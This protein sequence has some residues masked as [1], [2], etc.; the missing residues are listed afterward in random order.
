MPAADPPRQRLTP[1]ERAVCY[2][3][4]PRVIHPVTLG[5]IV[6]YAVC[7][8]EAV[9]ALAYG[10]VTGHTLYAT[11]GGYALA[12][13]I[14]FGL[15]VFFFRAL[16]NDIRQRRALADARAVP[17][18]SSS[19]AGLPDPFADH[20]LLAR[21]RD[22][23]GSLFAVTAN[24]S[25]IEYYVA[26]GGARGTWRIRTAAEAE[27]CEVRALSGPRSFRFGAA[28][29]ARLGVYRHGQEIARIV[30]GF[31]LF[32]PRVAISMTDSP[33]LRYAVRDFGIYLEGALIGRIYF[34]RNSYY[35]DMQRAR[36]NEGILAYFVT[37]S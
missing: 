10:V 37:V 17:E 21:P 15:V 9:A 16:L 28:L 22:N 35:L 24:D 33:A 29:P 14:L 18:R 1:Y 13:M 2:Y 26:P 12:G 20:L 30:R 34:L 32:R 25:T 11:V 19:A 36:F 6:A 3:T 27:V 7:I 8:L 31:G 23:R 5:L 4:L